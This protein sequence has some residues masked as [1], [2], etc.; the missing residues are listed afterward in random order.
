MK[1][2]AAG[3]TEVVE[4]D[5]ALTVN[6]SERRVPAGWTLADLLGSLD[7]DA[8]TVV[9]EHNGTILRD[10]SSFASHGLTEDDSLEIVHFVGGG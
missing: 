9:V 6:G 4:R 1:E 10:R 3:G 2:M 5:I 7:L 8:R